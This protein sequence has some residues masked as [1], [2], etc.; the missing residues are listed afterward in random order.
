MSKKATQSKKPAKSSHT[1]VTKKSV[2]RSASKPAAKQTKAARTQPQQNARRP[3]AD[4][5][6]GKLI[7]L[8]QGDDGATLAQL[9]KLTGWQPHTVRGVISGVLRKKL[10]LDVQS[11]KAPEGGERVYRIAGAAKTA[12]TLAAESA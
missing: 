9:T 1:S 12:T 4:S 11:S 10:K 6:Q 3:Q 2:A 7:K 8:L 5:K